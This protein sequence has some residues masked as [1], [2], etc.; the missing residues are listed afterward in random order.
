MSSRVHRV[1]LSQAWTGRLRRIESG[2]TLPGDEAAT[3]SS[4]ALL[5]LLG[6]RAKGKCGAAGS[7]PVNAS[8]S[9]AAT[10]APNNACPV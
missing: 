9:G 8:G 3:T 7:E 5:H 4:P 10:G 1:S 6:R 2:D